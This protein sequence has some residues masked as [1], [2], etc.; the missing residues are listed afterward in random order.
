MLIHKMLIRLAERF[1]DIT[2]LIP[3][4]HVVSNERLSHICHL[5]PYKSERQFT[6]DVDFLCKRYQ[7]ISLDDLIDFAKHGKKLRKGSFIITFDDGYSQIYSVVAPILVKKGIPAI[8]FLASDF[9]DNRNLG[10]RNKASLIVEQLLRDLDNLR[11]NKPILSEMLNV[12]CDQLT[13]RISAI[14]YEEAGVLDDIA[15]LIGIDFKEYLLREQPYLT[16]SQVRSLIEMGFYFGAHSMDHPFFKDLP[17]QAQLRQTIGSL[18]FIKNSYGLPYSIFAFPH[19]DYAISQEY[20][21]KIE[22]IMD[23]TFGTCGIKKDPIATNLQRI[24]FERTPGPADRIIARQLI[25]KIVYRRSA[26]MTI[27]RNILN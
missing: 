4:Y 8:F 12:P 27:N 23:L 20:F 2:P 9:I 3:Y 5:H 19:D 21:I 6:D 16:S 7:S 11:G 24:N 22:N 1:S 26:N 25:K 10:Y 15:K 18:E 17:M 13:K 14:R